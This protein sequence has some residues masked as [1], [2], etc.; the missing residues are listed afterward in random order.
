MDGGHVIDAAMN[1][2]PVWLRAIEVGV[3]ALPGT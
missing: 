1:A 2:D 3:A